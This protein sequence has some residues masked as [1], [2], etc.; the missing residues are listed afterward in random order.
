MSQV[1]LSLPLKIN[2]FINRLFP[3]KL[4]RLLLMTALQTS[5]SLK[6][7]QNL[8][9]KN[10]EIFPN[11]NDFSI[12]EFQYLHTFSDVIFYVTTTDLLVVIK[13]HI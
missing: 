7:F 13:K 4:E 11:E 2:I 10:Q 12:E 9:N 6:Q 8:W 5:L 1:L 3:T